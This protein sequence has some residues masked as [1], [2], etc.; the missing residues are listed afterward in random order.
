MDAV[1]N[2]KPW[3]KP[4]QSSSRV[5]IFKPEATSFSNGLEMDEGFFTTYSVV[6][7]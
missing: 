7:T 4:Q 2:G 6:G 5:H 3:S 1:V